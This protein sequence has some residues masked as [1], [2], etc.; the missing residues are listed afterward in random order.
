MKNNHLQF[1]K[2]RLFSISL[3]L[4]GII[5]ILISNSC[6]KDNNKVQDEQNVARSTPNVLNSASFKSASTAI[7]YGH[8]KFT[9]TTAAPRVIK[10]QI[11]GPDLVHFEKNFTL[12]IQNG[13][14]TNNLVSSAEIKIDGKHIAGPSDFSQN[15]SLI[16]KE[17][18]GLTE[19]SELEVEL[20]GSPGGFIDLWIEGTPKSPTYGAIVT[21]I[22]GNSYHTVLV[23]NQW[24]MVENL[25][26]T[27]YSDGEPIPYVTDNILWNSL[28]TGAYCWYN[29]NEAG[30]K[31]DY[32]ALYNQYAA[33]SDKLS[34]TGWHVPSFTE[35]TMLID[36]LG[37][38]GVAAGKLKESG[39]TYWERPNS[40]ATN[41]SGFAALPGGIRALWDDG[42]SFRGINTEGSWWNSTKPSDIYNISYWVHL[43]YDFDN[44]GYFGGSNS[45][46]TGMSIRCI[47]D[48]NA[49]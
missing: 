31:P 49:P 47:K 44:V 26:A 11:G 33:Y 7:Y 40:G 13:D 48:Q 6:K 34:P 8:E 14:G 20:K 35:W 19:T 42:T 46:T 12:F 38:E 25:K 36:Y 29:N 10:K 43:Q 21:D 30:Y 22:D 24:W 16:S 23:G 15:V 45:E 17:I 9:R 32:G 18:T 28:S 4:F 2:E 41:E 37:G 5:A 27:H 39:I 1:T 3:F